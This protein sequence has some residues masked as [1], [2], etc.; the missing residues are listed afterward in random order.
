M[1]GNTSGSEL[2]IEF[3]QEVQRRGSTS[4]SITVPSEIRRRLGLKP[5]DIVKVRI[6]EIRKSEI[7][8]PPEGTGFET[9]Y[10]RVVFKDRKFVVYDGVT[11]SVVGEVSVEDVEKRYAELSVADEE[12][13]YDPVCN[14]K[15]LEDC[16][17][18]YIATV[19]RVAELIRESLK[20]QPTPVSAVSVFI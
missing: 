19:I 5:G 16:V 1:G 20:Q 12:P 10:G 7:L 14:E 11:N 18:S 6:V 13:A 9:P 15:H 17:K 3:E 4:L 2:E 8:I